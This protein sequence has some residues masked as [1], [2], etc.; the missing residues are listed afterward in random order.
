MKVKQIVHRMSG[1]IEE[2]CK[3]GVGHPTLASAKKVAKHYGH[4][5]DTWLTHGCCGCCG[6]CTEVHE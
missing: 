1:I 4:P 5:V 6:C 3:C 2:V